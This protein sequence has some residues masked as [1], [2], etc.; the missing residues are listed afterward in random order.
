[1]RWWKSIGLSVEKEVGVTRGLSEYVG[2]GDAK[3][4]LRQRTN[5][6]HPSLHKHKIALQ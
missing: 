4:R 6:P 3:G 2:K 1:M 5:L